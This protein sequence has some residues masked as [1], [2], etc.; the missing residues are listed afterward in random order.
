M[1]NDFAAA[2]QRGLSETYIQSFLFKLIILFQRSFCF[3]DCIVSV[4]LDHG[5]L[6]QHGKVQVLFLKLLHISCVQLQQ[7]VR[8]GF[9]F[10]AGI[11]L[12]GGKTA[13]IAF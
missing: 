1:S 9:Q 10:A 11:G 3:F 7:F 4:E 13:H 5:M 8:V 12:H 2:Q 6:V